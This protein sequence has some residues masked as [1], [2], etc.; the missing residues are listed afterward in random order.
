MEISHIVKVV[1]WWILIYSGDHTE[2][3]QVEYDPSQI[4]YQ[5]LL[6]IFWSLHDP[7]KVQSPQY[8]SAIFVHNDKQHRLAST[9]LEE[10]Q[11]ELSG[12]VLTVVEGASQFFDAEG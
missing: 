3:I 11:R 10:K 12:R 1:Y 8:R 2:S 6:D 9:S 5:H 7:V 4:T